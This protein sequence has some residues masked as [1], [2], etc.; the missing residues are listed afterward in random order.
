[1]KCDN[2]LKCI[3]KLYTSMAGKNNSCLN[4]FLLILQID[5]VYVQVSDKKVGISN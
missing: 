2:I 1:M 5:P 4:R 3:K